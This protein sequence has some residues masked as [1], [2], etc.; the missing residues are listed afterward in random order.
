[1]GL[2]GGERRGK[3]GG[4]WFERVGEE[5]GPTNFAFF[6][7]SASGA[8]FSIDHFRSDSII[9][10]PYCAVYLTRLPYTADA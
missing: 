4:G 10:L 7:P 5:A 8:E 2:G 9:A 3:R 1:M 6:S